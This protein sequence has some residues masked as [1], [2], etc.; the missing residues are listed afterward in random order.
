MRYVIL[1]IS[2]APAKGRPLNPHNRRASDADEAVIAALVADD[3]RPAIRDRLGIGP[4]EPEPDDAPVRGILL[5]VL[6]GGMFWVIAAS[7]YLAVREPTGSSRTAMIND[8]PSQPDPD[9]ACRRTGRTSPTM[10][11]GLPVPD[12]GC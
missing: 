11:D 1:P 7:V 8:P 5:A 12:A 10:F 6:I 2:A 4:L 3:N 9:P